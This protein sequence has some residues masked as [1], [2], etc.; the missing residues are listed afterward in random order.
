MSRRIFKQKSELSICSLLPLT[1][2]KASRSGSGLPPFGA[3]GLCNT[4]AMLSVKVLWWVA[5][6]WKRCAPDDC[7]VAVVVCLA[8]HTLAGVSPSAVGRDQLVSVRLKTS[9][10]AL[11]RRANSVKGTSAVIPQA[12]GAQDVLDRICL[13]AH[14]Q[15]H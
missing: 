4:Q 2:S 6:P 7:L 3:T 13:P 14:F 8:V 1:N 10:P 9:L 5:Q 15:A 12:I 11:T